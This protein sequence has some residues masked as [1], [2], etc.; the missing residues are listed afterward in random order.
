[1]T[2]CPLRGACV[3]CFFA[4]LT[5]RQIT[6]E[7]HKGQR[8]APDM[9]NRTMARARIRQNEVWTAVFHTSAWFYETDVDDMLRHDGSGGDQHA[10]IIATYGESIFDADDNLREQGQHGDDS[11]IVVSGTKNGGPTEARWDSFGWRLESWFYDRRGV[12]DPEL[13]NRM[14]DDEIASWE[15]DYKCAQCHE[16]QGDESSFGVHRWGQPDALPVC[17]DCFEK[18]MVKALA[19]AIAR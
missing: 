3:R 13:S 19:T 6:D 17:C 7:T 12:H 10:E 14:I 16:V 15:I 1:M 9:E 5:S 8:P 18:N 11:I 2:S 4:S